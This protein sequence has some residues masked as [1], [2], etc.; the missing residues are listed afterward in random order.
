MDV[1]NK[2]GLTP[3]IVTANNGNAGCLRMLLD[4]MANI[5]VKRKDG[6]TALTIA[7]AKGYHNIVNML[8]KAKQDRA[9]TL[10]V[11]EGPPSLSISSL[12]DMQAHTIRELV[13]SK[14][15]LVHRLQR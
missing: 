10:A 13:N 11:Q 3:L 15:S 12:L 8:L 2:D 14:A 9:S 1:A 4:A 5:D 6:H 7:A